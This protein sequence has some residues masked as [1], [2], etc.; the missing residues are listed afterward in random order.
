MEC[1]NGTQSTGIIEDVTLA[2]ARYMVVGLQIVTIVR[3]TAIV[4]A[5]V[6][7]GSVNSDS[8]SRS[9]HVWQGYKAVVVFQNNLWLGLI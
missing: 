5:A 9:P 8:L 3:M 7:N 6:D 2:H 4:V 1:L